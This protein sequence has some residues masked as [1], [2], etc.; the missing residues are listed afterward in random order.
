MEYA[1]KEILSENIEIIN[2]KCKKKLIMMI[3]RMTAMLIMTI[4][5]LR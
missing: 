5:K 2:L 1:R 4:I 3:I